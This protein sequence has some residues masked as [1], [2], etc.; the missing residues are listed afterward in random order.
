[1]GALKD[2]Y[3]MIWEELGGS[4]A[5]SGS[6]D[7]PFAENF[8]RE[9]VRHGV[10]K[11]LNNLESMLLLKPR[12]KGA[13]LLYKASDEAA[14][15]D[16]LELIVKNNVTAKRY[17]EILKECIL[18]LDELSTAEDEEETKALHKDD[19]SAGVLNLLH[20]QTAQVRI[21]CGADVMLE[22]FLKHPKDFVRD[23]LLN[24]D[25]K[26]FSF[27][28]VTFTEDLSSVEL[29]CGEYLRKSHLT[30]KHNAVRKGDERFNRHALRIVREIRKRDRALAQSSDKKRES[31]EAKKEKAEEALVKATMTRREALRDAFRA[32]VISDYYYRERCEQLKKRDYTRVPEMFEADE[33]RDKEQYLL[34]HDLQD[35]SKEER[36]DICE[37]ARRKTEADKETY[38][39]KLFLTHRALARGGRYMISE[40]SLNKERFYRGLA[41]ESGLYEESPVTDKKGSPVREKA[42]EIGSDSNETAARQTPPID[43]KTRSVKK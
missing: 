7:A 24:G 43:E 21:L 27:D 34:A 33:L 40:M 29:D 36:A 5:F 13:L 1:M 42:G 17:V 19:L 8:R 14:P 28:E 2:L 12:Q 31:L 16:E 6:S 37:L 10:T 26:L 32:G 9:M 11:E 15:I 39:K 20:R 30:V 25:R 41:A 4:R 22:R 23:V 3:Q 38:Y 35:L 18:E